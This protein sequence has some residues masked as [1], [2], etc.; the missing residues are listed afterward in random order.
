MIRGLFS[1]KYLIILLD[2]DLMLILAVLGL[3]VYGG[4]HIIPLLLFTHYWPR[5]FSRSYRRDQRLRS[6]F[7]GAKKAVR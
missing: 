3:G 2:M 1:R 5:I 6:M 4:I 7:R